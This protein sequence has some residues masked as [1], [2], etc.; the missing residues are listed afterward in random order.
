MKDEYLI[1]TPTKKEKEFMLTVFKKLVI[2]NNTFRSTKLYFDS[3]SDFY[4][5][6]IDRYTINL[7]AENYKSIYTN[8]VK[9][10]S[11]NYHI[12]KHD[13]ISFCKKN[14]IIIPTFDDGDYIH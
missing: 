2:Y 6:L 1:R 12:M 9:N 13:V 3:Y 10:I 5:E 4:T 8:K 14:K 7:M 11:V